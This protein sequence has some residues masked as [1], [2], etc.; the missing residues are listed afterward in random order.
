MNSASLRKTSPI[1]SLITLITLAFLS[2]P[3]FAQTPPPSGSP[4]RPQGKTTPPPPQLNQPRPAPRNTPPIPLNQNL[5]TASLDITVPASQF[6]RINLANGTISLQAA[7]GGLTNFDVTITPEIPTV[8]VNGQ[9]LSGSAFNEGTHIVTIIASTADGR[10][11]SESF[12]LTIIED[13]SAAAT[14][15]SD[16]SGFENG[17]SLPANHF[18]YADNQTGL[19][20]YYR[21]GPTANTD[22]TPD[23]N[24]ITNAGATLGR[25]LFYDVKLSGNDTTSCASCHQQENGFSDPNQLS[26]GFEGGLTGRHSMSLVNARFYE[27][28]RFFWDERATTLEEQVLLPIQDAVEMGMTLTELESKLADTPYYPPLFADAF[29]DETVT[30]ERISL[31]LAQFVRSIVSFNTKFD[32]AFTGGNNGVF[33]SVYT[34]QELQGLILF[35]QGGDREGRSLG[36]ARCHGTRAHVSDDVH[37]NGL[38][39]TVTGDDG[40]G[41]KRFK[42]PSLRNIAL[43]APYMHDGRFSTLE[44]VIEFYDGGV[45][46][47]PELDNRLTG[48]GG[49]PR[50]LNMSNDEKAALLAFLG[51]LTDATL[52]TDIR[53]SDP[54]NQ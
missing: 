35:G 43:T 11:I 36:C 38:D 44:E 24:P 45:Q 41:N 2:I 40:A 23:N 15:P 26:V 4:P 54:F 29:G 34:E 50:R 1:N 28:G 51:T 48:P 13:N 47:H 17:P 46:G 22:N 32:S 16:V 5:E 7:D 27:R 37:N 25:V 18:A 10:T 53:F 14:T 12:T 49:R 6:F 52:Q 9:F 42:S 20:G 31:A 30:S 21:N 8:S 19:P 3:V 33:E 39:I